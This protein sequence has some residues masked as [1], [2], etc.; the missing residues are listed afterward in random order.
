MV[1]V[2]LVK[3]PA[4]RDRKQAS[5]LFH[6]LNLL[7]ARQGKIAP[8]P[9]TIVTSIKSSRQQVTKQATGKHHIQ[10]RARAPIGMMLQ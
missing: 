3:R 1:S 7:N 10:R 9:W 4:Y 2:L 8:K 6:L 5:A